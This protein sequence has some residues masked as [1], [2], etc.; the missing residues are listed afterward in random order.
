M[1]PAVKQREDRYED[2]SDAYLSQ[3]E[4]FSCIGPELKSFA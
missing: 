3:T 4:I 1:D 2:I